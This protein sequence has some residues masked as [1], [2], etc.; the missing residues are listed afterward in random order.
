MQM[1]N[2]PDV[3]PARR[4]LAVGLVLFGIMFIVNIGTAILAF[5]NHDSDRWIAV[6]RLGVSIGAAV[7]LWRGYVL[8][9]VLA[10]RAAIY[11]QVIEKD[12]PRLTAIVKDRHPGSPLDEVEAE[13][14]GD[15][16]KLERGRASS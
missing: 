16:L 6:L 11:R 3:Q 8:L 15:S 1:S 7:L 9:A 13:H 5:S 2:F 12:L 10:E 14:V 4:L